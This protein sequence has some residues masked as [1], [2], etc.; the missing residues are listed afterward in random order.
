MSHRRARYRTTHKQTDQPGEEEDRRPE[1]IGDTVTLLIACRVAQA[2]QRNQ[3][4]RKQTDPQANPR[5]TA[6]CPEQRQQLHRQRK[7]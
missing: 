7:I 6:L 2:D 3:H 5:P 4:K 1:Q